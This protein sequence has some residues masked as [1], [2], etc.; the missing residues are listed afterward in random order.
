VGFRPG[1]C[2]LHALCNLAQA[3]DSQPAACEWPTSSVACMVHHSGA[4]YPSIGSSASL[5]FA[6]LR[7]AALRMAS[8]SGEAL[9]SLSLWRFL[10]V[11]AWM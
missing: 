1:R 10:A 11:A 6:S 4:V 9:C 5:R 7:C 8:R 3:C 2:G